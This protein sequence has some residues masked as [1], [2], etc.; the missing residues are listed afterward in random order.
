MLQPYGKGQNEKVVIF[1]VA[2]LPLRAIP[3]ASHA[4]PD[5]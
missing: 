4:G 1:K 5:S 3:D 2:I